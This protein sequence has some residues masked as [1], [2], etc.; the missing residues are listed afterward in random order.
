[1]RPI[2][3]WT[4]RESCRRLSLIKKFQDTSIAFP[5]YCVSNRGSGNGQSSTSYRFLRNIGPPC[6]AR[7]ERKGYLVSTIWTS[8]GDGWP[9]PLYCDRSSFIFIF[10]ALRKYRLRRRFEHRWIIPES[11][12]WWKRYEFSISEPYILYNIYTYICTTYH[13]TVSESVFNF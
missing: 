9:I 5:R 7:P 3:I 2:V 4:H 8:S 11:R 13:S 10:F 12:I 1:M 6:A